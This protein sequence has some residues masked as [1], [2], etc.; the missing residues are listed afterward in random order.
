LAVVVLAG[1]LGLSVSAAAS[2]MVVADRRTGIAINGYDPV[3]YFTDGAPA[4]GHGDFEYAFA[5]AVWRFRNEGNRGAF[6]AD[7]EIYMP[8]FGGYDPI[9]VARGVAVPGDPRR[10]GIAGKRLYLFYTIDNKDI[11]LAGRQRTI[12]AADRNW[13]SVQLTLAP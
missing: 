8:R 1:G 12:A 7:P 6:V 10:W 4:L 9:G 11:F 5:G 3:A 13:P 2:E